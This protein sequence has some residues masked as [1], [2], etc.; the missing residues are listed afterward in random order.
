MP[1]GFMQFK[2]SKLS[3]CIC[4]EQSKKLYFID[5]EGK[6]IREAADYK[7]TDV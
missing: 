5:V 7:K 4:Y 3:R 1:Y 6:I 2:G